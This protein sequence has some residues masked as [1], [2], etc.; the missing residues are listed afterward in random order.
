[1][2]RKG[3]LGKVTNLDLSDE[4]QLY[5][6]ERKSISKGDRLLSNGLEVKEK[7]II[8]PKFFWS[9][10]VATATCFLRAKMT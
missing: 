2:A 4:S 7:G 10:L 5:P 6:S 1:M 3:F 9:N 8:P